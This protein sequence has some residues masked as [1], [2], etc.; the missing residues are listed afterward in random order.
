M[1]TLSFV[2]DYA[3]TTVLNTVKSLAPM[4]CGVPQ[5]LLNDP[6]KTQ[7]IITVTATVPGMSQPLIVNAWLQEKIDLTVESSWVPV[8]DMAALEQAKIFGVPVGDTARL[9][10]GGN[11]LLSTLMSRR[12][13]L[14]TSPITMSLKMRFEAFNDVQN[15]VINPCKNLHS[16]A[17][18]STGGNIG[19]ESFFLRPPGPNPFSL[20]S[21]TTNAAIGGYQPFGPGE[22]ITVNIG[23]FLTFD[24]VI[25]KSVKVTYESRMT[26]QG[27]VGAE[28]D[29]VIET[30]EMPTKESLAKFYSSSSG[31]TGN[32]LIDQG[33]GL[34]KIGGR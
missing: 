25:I 33:L 30:Y 1:G 15:E 13:W 2:K 3:V 12:K 10:S 7:Y 5:S 32:N 27:P 8:V 22:K 14:G 18:P 34:L 23:R 9:L 29:V 24:S 20:N 28:A 16:L 6:T 26:S 17:C 11:S 31:I 19:G 21:A 4:V